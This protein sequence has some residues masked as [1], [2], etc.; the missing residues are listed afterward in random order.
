LLSYLSVPISNGHGYE[1][2]RE[3]RTCGYRGVKLL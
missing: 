3:P 2:G 1:D